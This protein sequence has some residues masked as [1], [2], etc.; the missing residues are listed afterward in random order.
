MK[1]PAHIKTAIKEQAYFGVG[2]QYYL[3]ARHAVFCYLFPVNGNLFHHAIEMFLLAGLSAK[4]SSKELKEKYH[5]H[6]LW[7]MWVDFKGILNSENLD[8]FD[9]LIK[10]YNKWEEI[11]YP[12]KK[13]SNIVMFSDIRKGSK[14]K[15]VDPNHKKGDEYRINLEEMDEFFKVICEVLSINPDYIRSMLSLGDSKVTYEKDNHHKVWE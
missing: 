15:F 14:S 6:N 1:V 10:R 3:T 12:L 5:K 2:L 11:R 7:Q 9:S 13:K 4:Y 8:G